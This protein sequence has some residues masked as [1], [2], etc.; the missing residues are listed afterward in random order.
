MTYIVFAL[1]QPSRIIRATNSRVSG[2]LQPFRFKDMDEA[3]R[4]QLESELKAL[5]DASPTSIADDNNVP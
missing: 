5:L 4:A 3:L 1:A 2:C